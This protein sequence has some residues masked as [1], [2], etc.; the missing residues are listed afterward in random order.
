MTIH[1]NAK[2]REC[3]FEKI[4]KEFKTKFIVYL[5]VRHYPFIPTLSYIFHLPR[6]ELHHRH[7]VS[8]D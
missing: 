7:R 5:F 8:S 1:V 3:F 6:T 4:G 2:E